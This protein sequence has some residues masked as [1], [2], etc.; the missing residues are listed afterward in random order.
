MPCGLRAKS[1]SSGPTP[2]GRRQQCYRSGN[3]IADGERACASSRIFASSSHRGFPYWLYF[4]ALRYPRHSE[5]NRIVRHSRQ[6]DSAVKEGKTSWASTSA[7]PSGARLAWLRMFASPGANQYRRHPGDLVSAF[8]FCAAWSSCLAVVIGSAVALPTGGQLQ[9]E[10]GG[11][12]LDLDQL[13][14]DGSGAIRFEAIPWIVPRVEAVPAVAT[15]V[16]ELAEQREQ[17]E[18]GFIADLPLF[19]V[20]ESDDPGAPLSDDNDAFD[21]SAGGIQ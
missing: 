18:A 5:R 15:R 17:I 2:L 3:A 8:L 6:H 21:A 1:S 7:R 19:A 11:Y 20:P 9:T 4:S 10:P 12:E 13:P 14:R 16:N